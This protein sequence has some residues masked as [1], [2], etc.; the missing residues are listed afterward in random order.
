MQIVRI[1]HAVDTPRALDSAAAAW[2]SVTLHSY[3]ILPHAYCIHGKY[4]NY[5]NSVTVT[6]PQCGMLSIT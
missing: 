6:V 3:T 5:A 2:A 4:N 1:S